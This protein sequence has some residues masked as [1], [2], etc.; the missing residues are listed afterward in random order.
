MFAV[1]LIF[2]YDTL[3]IRKGV[4]SQIERDAMLL[5]VRYV[6]ASIP[7][8][9][10]VH[11]VSNLP[12]EVHESNIIMWLQIWRYVSSANGFESLFKMGVPILKKWIHLLA[13]I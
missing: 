10:F 13:N 9:R 8:K 12:S 2:G 4:L 3:G 6:L 5:L 7:F 11:H 1:L